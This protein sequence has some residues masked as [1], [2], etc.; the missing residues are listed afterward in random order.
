MTHKPCGLM[1]NARHTCEKKKNSSMRRKYTADSYQ[2]WLVFSCCADLL[3]TTM[4]DLP[5]LGLKLLVL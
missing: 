1:T 3:V 4:M 5:H 2:C